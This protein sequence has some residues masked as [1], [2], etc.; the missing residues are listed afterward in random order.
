MQ[1]NDLITLN[2][3]FPLLSKSA[4]VFTIA[5]CERVKPKPHK[6]DSQKLI[7]VIFCMPNPAGNSNKI[8]K[9]SQCIYTDINVPSCFQFWR[10]LELF[11]AS[12]ELNKFQKERLLP[13]FDLLTPWFWTE[14]DSKILKS[15]GMWLNV[16]ACGVGFLGFLRRKNSFSDVS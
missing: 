14:S 10:W 9:I 7:L 11:F 4:I 16:N 3:A 8:T 5:I 1:E 13:H 2:F 6:E 15:P 12:G